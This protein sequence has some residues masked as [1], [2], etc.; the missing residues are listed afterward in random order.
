MV[1]DTVLLQTLYSLVRII[2]KHFTYVIIHVL[3][4]Y[5]DYK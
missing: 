1:E 5:G 2:H 4:L 3:I